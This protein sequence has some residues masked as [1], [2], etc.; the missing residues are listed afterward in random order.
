MI[1]RWGVF[2]AW[3]LLFLSVASPAV[4]SGVALFGSDASGIL[5]SAKGVRVPFF[6]SLSGE[7]FVTIHVDSIDPARYRLGPFSVAVPGYDLGNLRLEIYHSDC[8]VDDWN[9]FVQTFAELGKRA[10]GH[11]SVRLPGEDFDTT[12]ALIRAARGLIIFREVSAEPASPSVIF[13]ITHDG[14]ER[15]SVERLSSPVTASHSIP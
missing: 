5:I 2:A 8:S 11:L 10:R 1:S 4:V 3:M 15:L 14:G 9:Q 13:S 6:S 12:V 7:R